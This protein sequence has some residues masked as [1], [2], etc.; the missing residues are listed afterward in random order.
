MQI[1]APIL[2]I[3]PRS[4][5][6]DFSTNL[7]VSSSL[8][9]TKP[10]NS[11]HDG[12]RHVHYLPGENFEGDYIFAFERGWILTSSNYWRHHKFFE[13]RWQRSFHVDVRS[14]GKKVLSS[15]WWPNLHYG[16]AR[17]QPNGSEKVPV[18]AKTLAPNLQWPRNPDSSIRLLGRWHWALV[19]K[20]ADSW[21]RA[22][23]RST[24]PQLD[25]VQWRNEQ[26]LTYPDKYCYLIARW[27]RSF[28]DTW[29]EARFWACSW[30]HSYT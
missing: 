23:S 20:K 29:V 19:S 21:M 17:I 15:R 4:I 27:S 1:T 14:G 24:Y 25:Q 9:W 5:C 18:P 30:H 3:Q 28:R 16:A 10:L 22:I 12:T 11:V 8:L 6:D 7:S 13:D 26:A 2:D